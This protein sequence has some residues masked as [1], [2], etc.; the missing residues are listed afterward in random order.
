MSRQLYVAYPELKDLDKYARAIAERL[1]KLQPQ[2]LAHMRID[3]AD[4]ALV[5]ELPAPVDAAH[6][7]LVIRTHER[8]VLVQFDKHDMRL[9]SS[10]TPDKDF[11]AAITF[12]NGLLCEDIVVGVKVANGE[13]QESRSYRVT[14]IG[15]IAPGDVSYTR[16]WLGTYNRSYE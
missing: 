11:E 12:I 14:E 1:F 3:P 8:E 6:G 4:N 7:G 13:R 2:W 16:S 15:G 5:V 9:A 10:G